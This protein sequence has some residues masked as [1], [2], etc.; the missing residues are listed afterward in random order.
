[1]KKTRTEKYE[2]EFYVGYFPQAPTQTRLFIQK[3]VIVLGVLIV[4]VAGVLVVQQDPFST[5][6]F[7]FG[8]ST[9]VK[10][11]LMKTPV[12]HLLYSIGSDIDGKQ[13]YQNVV[14]VGQGKKGACD[15]IKEIEVSAGNAEGKYVEITGYLIYGDGKVLLQVDA[16]GDVRI[17]AGHD[18]I[19]ERV[20][21]VESKFDG[22]G[23]VVDPKCFFGVMKPGEG[24]P[25]R[26]CAIRCIAGGIPP[27]F[28]AGNSDYYLLVGEHDEPLN[29]EI[30]PVVGDR[31]RLQ[32]KVVVFGD[33]KIL[34]IPVA[35][36]RSIAEFR[37]RVNL[38]KY[39]NEEM[40]F[41]Y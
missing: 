35:E 11:Y 37:Q 4:C 14:L 41:C 1:M 25:H 21:G 39:S 22:V 28:N 32:G 18:S 10:G 3:F 16:A 27:V 8:R 20:P 31:I 34:K 40:T 17:L 38:I 5:A 36:V 6:Q 30:L 15:L 19:V 26:S 23:E 33:W 12:P 13:L 2:D 9:T 24:K 29:Q 7:D